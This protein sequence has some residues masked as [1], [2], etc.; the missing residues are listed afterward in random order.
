MNKIIEL[1]QQEY[2]YIRNNKQLLGSGVDGS[3]YK[4]NDNIVYKLYHNT[5][6]NIVI[7]NKG[8]YDSSGVNIRDFKTLRNE[9]ERQNNRIINYID[10]EGVNIAREQAI[11]KAFEKQDNIKYSKLPQQVIKVD[12]KTVGCVYPYYPYKLGI[13]AVSYLP[14]KLKLTIIY[15]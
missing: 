15:S 4:I 12:N 2:D 5:C 1:S 3:A 10:H 13:Y 9:G 7:K 6:D 14:L 11:L 8:V